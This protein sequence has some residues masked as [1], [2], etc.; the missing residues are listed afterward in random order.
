MR[1]L[2]HNTAW[3]RTSENPILKPYPGSP[4]GHTITMNPCIITHD[5]LLYLFYAADDGSGK[6][7]LRL[8]T[9][10]L[11]HP[12]DLTPRGTIVETGEPGSFDA[13]WCVLPNVVSP[14]PGLWHLYY[15]GNQGHGEGLAAFPGMGL[16]VSHDLIHWEKVSDQP[17]LT[18]QDEPGLGHAAG[19]AGGSVLCDSQPDGSKRFTWY[20]TVCPTLGADVFLDQQ[21]QISY[22]TS[23]DGIRWTKKGCL[24]TR[25]PGHDYENIAV[26]GPVVRKNADG[27]DMWYSA[28]GTRWGFYSICR[29]WSPDGLTWERGRTYGENLQLGPFTRGLKGDCQKQSWDSQM[30]AYPAVVQIGERDRLYYCGNAYGEGGIGTAVA[31]PLRLAATG[32]DDGAVTV[33]QYR[34]APCNLAFLKHLSRKGQ[35]GQVC[36]FSFGVQHDANVWMEAE[37]AWPQDDQHLSCRLLFEHHETGIDVRCTLINTSSQP[38]KGLAMRV[39]GA[40]GAG[41]FWDEAVP[42]GFELA[43]YRNQ[44]F[45]GRFRPL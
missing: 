10:P 17:L 33:W 32:S 37:L 14:E 45:T 34:Q 42:E 25:N 8:A 9:A 16:A 36:A 26:A 12:T 23:T 1:P 13:A 7:T 27:Y 6:R 22:A 38:M 2:S 11:A 15:T 44:T 20:Y 24:M 19:I 41:F 3:L 29:A 30:A 4:F 35:R 43:A 21:K 18:P 5:G 40:G 39:D 28:I 31:A